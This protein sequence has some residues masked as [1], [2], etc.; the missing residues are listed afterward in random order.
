MMAHI[1]LPAQAGRRR[2]EDYFAAAAAGEDTGPTQ[3]ELLQLRRAAFTNEEAAQW[4]LHP[5]THHERARWKAGRN[6]SVG[7]HV[8]F[9][10]EPVHEHLVVVWNF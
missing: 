8:S 9:G 6:A 2:Y 4:G 1:S 10:T 7:R 5:A 3:G